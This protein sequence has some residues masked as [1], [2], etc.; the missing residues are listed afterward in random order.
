MFQ[1]G[2]GKLPKGMPLIPD[3]PSRPENCT[4]AAGKSQSGKVRGRTRGCAV[5]FASPRRVC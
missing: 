5:R 4:E 3:V 2:M 1:G